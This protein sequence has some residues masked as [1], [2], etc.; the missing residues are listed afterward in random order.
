MA[1]KNIAGMRFGRLTAIKPTEKKSGSAI[2]WL[3]KCDCGNEKIASGSHLRN[4]FTK[5]CGCLH[6]ESGRKNIIKAHNAIRKH[7][8]CMYC[9][10]DKHYARGL[11]RSC[12][13]KARRG[14]LG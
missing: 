10:S 1:V 3:C 14:T 11:C 6:K 2:C 9:G 12:Y 7:F 8:G 4:G 5:S 13:N